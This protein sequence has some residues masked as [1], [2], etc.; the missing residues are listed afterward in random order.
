VCS[1][2]PI[3]T[4]GPE[5]LH[6]HVCGP[7]VALEVGDHLMMFTIRRRS[8]VSLF[9]ASVG[10]TCNSIVVSASSR[11]G[12]SSAFFWG[13]CHCTHKAG[14]PSKARRGLCLLCLSDDVVSPFLLPHLAPGV[15][16]C[17]EIYLRLGGALYFFGLTPSSLVA[18]N[19]ALQQAPE[20]HALQGGIAEDAFTLL[21]PPNPFR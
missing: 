21:F 7:H 4:A 6:P 18:N 11:R 20:H 15:R 9:L 1:T 3:R 2:R 17:S 10:R 8:Q 5:P 16:R 13:P 14:K 12:C 19:V